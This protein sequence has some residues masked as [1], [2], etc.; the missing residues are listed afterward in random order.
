MIQWKTKTATHTVKTVLKKGELPPTLSKQFQKTATHTVKTVPKNCHPH[1]QNSPKKLPPT[2]S[3]QSQKTKT[4]TH[5]VK[6][7]P[8]KQKLPPTLSKQFHKNCHPHCQ[9]S[10]K[11]GGWSYGSWFYNY[12][13]NQCL[14]PLKLWVW[15]PFMARCT[16]Y[17]IMW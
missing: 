13:C 16:W 9:N 10:S 6:T 11:K 5:T 1:C 7:V 12:L 4:A 14:S 2:L 17:R 8:K 3:K 15:T